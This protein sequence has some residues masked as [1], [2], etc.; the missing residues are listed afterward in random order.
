MHNVFTRSERTERKYTIGQAVA[1]AERRLN[2]ARIK[3]VC[4]N[5]VSRRSLSEKITLEELNRISDAIYDDSV[6]YA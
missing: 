5:A 1:S 3:G 4:M 6:Y 2:K